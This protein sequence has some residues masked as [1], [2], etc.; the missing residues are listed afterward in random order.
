[1]RKKFSTSKDI[2]NIE[3]F[4]WNSLNLAFP[5]ILVFFVLKKLKHFERDMRFLRHEKHSATFIP[6]RGMHFVRYEYDSFLLGKRGQKLYHT[7]SEWT[8][9]DAT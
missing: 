5:I 2:E 8:V 7:S 9:H 1:M 6:K 3:F 4:E